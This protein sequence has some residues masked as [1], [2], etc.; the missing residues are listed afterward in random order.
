V[1]YRTNRRALGLDSSEDYEMALLRLCAGEA[2][3]VRTEPEEA[4]IRFASEVDSPNPDLGLLHRVGSV[5][6]SLRSAALE[7]A[8]E[9][10]PEPE[11]RF[12]PPALPREPMVPP[13]PPEL[14]P[15]LP[16]LGPPDG[17]ERVGE[18][19]DLDALDDLDDLDSSLDDEDLPD[20]SG[21]APPHCLY[22]GGAL[23]GDRTVRFCPHCGQ[24]QTPPECPRCL[25][26]VDPGWRHCVN[27][28]AALAAG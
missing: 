7:R 9:E 5:V 10:E 8:L 23:P 11:L 4:R 14:E 1:P 24:R 16:A 25:S 18:G 17:F 26:E 28:G 6:I 12:A 20:G 15:D 13:P 22:C 2:N 27:C 19:D 3:L 21:A